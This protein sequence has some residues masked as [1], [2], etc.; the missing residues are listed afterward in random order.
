VTITPSNNPFFVDRAK[1]IAAKSLSGGYDLLLACRDLADM[2]DELPCVP[3]ELMDVFVGI[4][5]ETDGMPIG[6][7]REHWATEPL[8][9]KDLEA[10]DYRN[11]VR[12]IVAKA[13]RELVLILENDQSVS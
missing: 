11:R 12:D 6:R 4:A 10:G 8:R 9:L 13:L 1:E 2:R 5:S 7:E 3:G